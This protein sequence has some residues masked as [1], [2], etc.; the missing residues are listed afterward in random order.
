MNYR[1]F[2]GHRKPEFPIWKG[3]EYFE[4]PLPNPDASELD[5]Y[6]ADHRLLG[7]YAA[8]FYLCNQLRSQGN[9][10]GQITIAQYRRM[11]LNIPLGIKSTNC[12]WYRVLSPEAIKTIPVQEE[13][14]P[15]PGQSY[16]VGSG[17]ELPNG[18]LSNYAGSHY[19]RDILRFTAN[20]VDCGVL[21]N[22]GAYLFLS[23]TFLIPAPSCGSF[24]LESFL[25]IM[26]KLEKV[27]RSFFSAGYQMHDDPYQG[28][29]LDF[30]LERLNSYLLLEQLV[31]EGLDPSLVI[32]STTL[33]SDSLEVSRGQMAKTL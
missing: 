3:F 5:L 20:A 30:L 12:P 23:Q 32:G 13:V 10:K 24:R 33:I 7:N 17:L 15:L 29:V 25:D 11:V 16:L 27:T 22:T 14:L 1:Y 6:L 18:M 26:T 8:L 21:D 2:V 9:T 4:L 31:S 19:T 28:R